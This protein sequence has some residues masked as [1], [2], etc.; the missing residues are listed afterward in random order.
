VL[1]GVVVLLLIVDVLLGGPSR[2]PVTVVDASG[3]LAFFSFA[4]AGFVVARRQPGNAIGWLLMGGAVFILLSDTSGG[5]AAWNYRFHHGTLP[6]GL[7][8]VFLQLGWA[9]AIALFPLP[10]LLFPDG[11]VSSRRWRWVLWSYLA[12]AALWVSSELGVAASGVIGQHISVDASGQLTLLDHP[13]G[14]AAV[15]YNVALGW[16]V[17][18]TVYSLAW[19]ARLLSRFRRSSGELRQ[20]LKWFLGGASIAAIGF[21]GT[22]TVANR[23]GTIGQVAGVVAFLALAAL[24]VGLGVGILKYRL[25]DVDRIIS[26]TLS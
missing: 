22:E 24:P 20:Q 8:A 10:V 11:H 19:V 6:G 13:T 26:R 15:V 21:V 1:L 25:F 12:L 23:P 5:Y 4:M 2:Q 14:L 9:P 17:V 18:T 3:L 16:T 7:A